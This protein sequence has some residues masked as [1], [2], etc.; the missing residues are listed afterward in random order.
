MNMKIILNDLEIFLK[1]ENLFIIKNMTPL[2]FKT[3]KFFEIISGSEG[4]V[5]IS[6]VNT[7][8]IR[9]FRN[10]VNLATDPISDA[11]KI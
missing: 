1:R 7:R 9:N 4:S 8:K 10:K 6:S 11:K 5:Y 3:F 2:S